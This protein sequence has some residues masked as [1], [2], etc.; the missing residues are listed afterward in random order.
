LPLI[1][2]ISPEAAEAEAVLFAP[3]PY[4]PGAVPPDAFCPD[5]DADEAV[6]PLLEEHAASAS[7]ATPAMPTVPIVVASRRDVGGGRC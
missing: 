5:E 7:A 1:C 2:A 6:P 4:W 3:A